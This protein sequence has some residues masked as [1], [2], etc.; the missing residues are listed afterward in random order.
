MEQRLADGDAG[1]TVPYAIVQRDDLL[2]RVGQAR[3]RADF[4]RHRGVPAGILV[5]V[6]VTRAAVPDA[7]DARQQEV[8]EAAVGEAVRPGM[9]AETVEGNGVRRD[10]APRSEEHTS[11]LQSRE[12]LVCR[13]LLEKKKK[14][15]RTITIG[16]PELKRP[17]SDASSSSMLLSLPLM[18]PAPGLASLGACHLASA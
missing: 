2:L 18:L 16:S 11:E 17:R 13:L 6:R 12:N 1:F 10:P 15:H 14:K 3:M 7:E 5:G 4:Q 9:P 8:L